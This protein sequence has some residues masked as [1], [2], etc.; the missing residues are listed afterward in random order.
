MFMR[1]GMPLEDA[2]TQAMMDLKQ[3][4]DPFASEMNIVGLDRDGNPGAVSTS[5]EKTYVIMDESMSTWD[6]RERTIVDIFV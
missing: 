4:D 1:F 5:E 6:E 2:L 3:L